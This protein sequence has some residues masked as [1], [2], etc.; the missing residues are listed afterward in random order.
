MIGNAVR[1]F[2]CRLV[3]KEC[4][5]PLRS[6]RDLT[7]EMKATSRELDDHIAVLRFQRKSIERDNIVERKYIGE[8]RGD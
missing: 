4:Y 1:R 2:I 7:R 3:G 8:A 6:T 5:A